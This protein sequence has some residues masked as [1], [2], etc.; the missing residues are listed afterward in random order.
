MA[1]PI[2]VSENGNDHEVT[3]R[4]NANGFVE[5]WCNGTMRLPSLT[6][7]EA[8]MIARALVRSAE[9]AATR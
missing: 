9:N 2:R 3:T 7:F 6:P 4:V 5:L 8:G 1:E